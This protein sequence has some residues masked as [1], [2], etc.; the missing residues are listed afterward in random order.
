M[1]SQRDCDPYL[2]GAASL[3]RALEIVHDVH[4]QRRVEHGTHDDKVLLV[5]LV[6]LDAVHAVESRDE[7]V[8]VLH[9]MLSTSNNT[10]CKNLIQKRESEQWTSEYM[11]IG[12]HDGKVGVVIQLQRES[13][14]FANTNKTEK[15]KHEY[16][17]VTEN[18]QSL[19]C[20][21]CNTAAAANA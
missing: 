11:C 6:R 1:V 2:G 13:R 7:R 10:V 8:G 19:T 4:I 5:A 3:R 21:P 18:R 14:I 16:W 9:H 12:K 17:K 20:V 15:T